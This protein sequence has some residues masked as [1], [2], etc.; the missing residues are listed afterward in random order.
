MRISRKSHLHG[1]VGEKLTLQVLSVLYDGGTSFRGSIL[2]YFFIG[3][4][5]RE[6]LFKTTP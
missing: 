6:L 2:S 1:L 3:G 4:R 5:R